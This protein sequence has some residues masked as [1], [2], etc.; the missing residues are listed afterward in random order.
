[1]AKIKNVGSAKH[2]EG[3]DSDGELPF[4]FNYIDNNDADN[5]VASSDPSDV[6]EA[7]TKD[8][9]GVP[10]DLTKGGIVELGVTWLREEL[11]C[12]GKP[13][14]GVRGVLP[15]HLKRSL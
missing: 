14:Y 6:A 8:N 5:N 10:V 15:E 12:W 1:M 9:D 3:Y 7:A 11:S 13:I 4:Y 2:A